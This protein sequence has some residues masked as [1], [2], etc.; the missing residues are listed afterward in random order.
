MQDEPNIAKLDFP[1]RDLY[2]TVDSQYEKTFRAHAC[3]K[4]PFTVE[5]IKNTAHKGVFYDVGANVGSYSLIAASLMDDDGSLVVAFEPAY[6]NF[7]KLTENMLLNRL[8][9]RIIPLPVA[10]LSRDY[11]GMM[12]LASTDFGATH[13]SSKL[14]VQHKVAVMYSSIDHLVEHFGL[15]F[16]NHI[17]IDVDGGEMDVISGGRRTFRDARLQTVMIEIDESDPGGTAAVNEF[18]AASG[19]VAA[20]RFSLMSKG[21]KNVLFVRKE[22]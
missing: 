20:E 11:V 17:K 2:I 13:G 14:G 15:P 18:M 22:G 1:D 3:A 7:F 10:L 19:F 6:P 16:P 21:I 5:W 12:G 9:E 8:S 4:E